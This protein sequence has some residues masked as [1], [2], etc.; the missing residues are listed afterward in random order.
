MKHRVRQFELASLAWALE[1][2]RRAR[3]GAWPPVLDEI[4][5]DLEER[6][7][8]ETAQSGDFVLE[9]RSAQPEDAGMVTVTTS[10]A[11]RRF[12]VH[13]QTIARMIDRGELRAV[14]IGARRRVR[15]AD[16]ERIA[17]GRAR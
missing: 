17:E 7:L 11:A 2:G 6:V 9:V 14:V 8:A 4:R 13:R 1:Q 12:G 16:L 15:L 10:E 5:R 3:V